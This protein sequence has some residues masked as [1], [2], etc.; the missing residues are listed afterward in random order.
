MIPYLL[1]ITCHLQL[2]TSLLF[3]VLTVIYLIEINTD[4]DSNDDNSDSEAN[5]TLVMRTNVS[6]M[7]SNVCC[8]Y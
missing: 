1:Q 2:K 4:T 8:S 3:I 7:V 6:T 5:Q